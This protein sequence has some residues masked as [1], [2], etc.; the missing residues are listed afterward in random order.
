M[1]Q[2]VTSVQKVNL[3]ASSP[4]NLISKNL[5]VT[6]KDDKTLTVCETYGTVMSSGKTF[7]SDIKCKDVQVKDMKYEDILKTMSD[8]YAKLNKSSRKSH[9][10]RTKKVS[11]TKKTRK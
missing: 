4:I 11:K 5:S 7:M 9:K 1:D 6:K 10:K 3:D 8:M 2:I